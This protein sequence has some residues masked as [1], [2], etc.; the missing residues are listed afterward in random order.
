[1]CIWVYPKLQ[2]VYIMHTF[3]SFPSHSRKLIEI[4]NHPKRL[5]WSIPTNSERTPYRLNYQNHSNVSQIHFKNPPMMAKWDN[6]K[7]IYGC[8]PKLQSLQIMC[9][10]SS[11][12][13]THTLQSNAK[14]SK[15][16]PNTFLKRNP[17]NSET[18]PY[19]LKF[20]LP[21]PYIISQ[22]HFPNH[23]T[24][25]KWEKKNPK[26]IWTKESDIS[27]Q[28]A[29]NQPQIYLKHQPSEKRQ[30][31]A[32]YHSQ[33]LQIW[34]RPIWEYEEKHSIAS[35]I[36]GKGQ[37]RASQRWFGDPKAWN[38]G[39]WGGFESIEDR[40]LADKS[41]GFYC[42]WDLGRIFAGIWIW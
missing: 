27:K 34:S 32:I 17:T 20:Q 42:F 18:N 29:I 21:K 13:L 37:E 1:M 23:P 14:P 8:T 5:C 10:L 4:E 24:T 12:D 36:R 28:K 6:K 39:K 40:F 11:S 2:S 16:T 3:L 41:L 30:T 33:E 31:G 25:P 19:G 38:G 26:T 35:E 15:H 7:I 22:F 9:L